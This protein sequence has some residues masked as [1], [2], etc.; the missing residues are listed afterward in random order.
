MTCIEITEPGGPE[1]LKPTSRPIPQPDDGE[2]LL[3]VKAAGINRPDCIQRQ[4]HYAPPTGVTDIPGLE[5]A[6]EII[7]IGAGVQNHKIGDLVCALI[8]G[9]GYAKYAVAP[10]IQCLPIPKNLSMIEAASLPET[11]YT[12]WFNVVDRAELKTG[13]SILIHGG[14]SGIGTSAIQICSQLG[15][16]VITTASTKE[17]C[18]VCSNLGAERTINYHEEDFVLASKDFTDGKGLD[19]V[20]DM[21]GGEYLQRNIKSLGQDGRHISI[22]FLSG[23]KAHIN[24]MPIM[25]KRIILTGSTLRPLSIRRKGEIADSLRRVIWPLIEKGKI[26]P[27]VHSIFSLEQATKAH[28]LMESN[29][30][31]GKIILVP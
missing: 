11:F 14:S 19:V 25:L 29:K 1:V 26:M 6:G 15:A 28:A 9:G 31:I 30:H 4:G 27:V 7:S 2:V 13:E 10:A 20:L 22:A 3:E 18:K 24:F 23:A 16:R 8:S 12:V 5:V 17:K 21:V